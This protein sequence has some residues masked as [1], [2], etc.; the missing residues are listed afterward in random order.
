VEI[1]I[2]RTDFNQDHTHTNHNVAGTF[3]LHIRW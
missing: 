2:V 3:G 1:D